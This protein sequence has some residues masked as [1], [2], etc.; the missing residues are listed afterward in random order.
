M[1]VAFIGL[2]IMGMPMATNISKKYDLIGC[3]VVDKETPFPFTK[4]YKECVEGRD[5]IIA[6]VPKSEHALALYA[7]L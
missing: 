2:G 1:K 3:D 5:L 4:S 6:M 7:E